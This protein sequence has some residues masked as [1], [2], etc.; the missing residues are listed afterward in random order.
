MSMIT[1]TEINHCYQ[2]K[3]LEITEKSQ[4]HKSSWTG[5]Y[6]LSGAFVNTKKYAKDNFALVFER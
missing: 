6:R 5:L 2:S 1:I 4:P 3:S